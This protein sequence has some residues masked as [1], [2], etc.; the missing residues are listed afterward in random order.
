MNVSL[1]NQ[2]I[3]FAPQRTGSSI[4]K[5][6]FENYNFFS[7]SK[8][9][10]YKLVDFKETKHSHEKPHSEEYS[11]FKKISNV[12]NPYDWIFAHYQKFYLEKPI[13]KNSKNH[14]EKFSKWVNDNFWSLGPYVFLSTRYSVDENF[15]REWT[16]ENF[17]VDFYIRM[18]NLKDDISKLPFIQ[19]NEQELMRIELLID[20]NEFINERHFNFQDVYDLKTAK[21]IYEF[22]K[23]SF[24]KF[25]YDPFSFT[26]EKFKDSEKISF[27]H[28]SFD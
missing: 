10:G 18:E 6:I 24:Y 12:R 20:E 16:F 4:T 28:Q 3:W 27:L 25:G 5:K 26:K 21:V 7:I 23:P 19:K 9:S 11:H 17:D 15:F 13:L 2:I 8:K 1:E 22:F 14:K